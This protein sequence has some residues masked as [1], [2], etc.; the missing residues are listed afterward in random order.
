MDFKYPYQILV[1]KKSQN[2]QIVLVLFHFKAVILYCQ[3][4]QEPSPLLLILDI[5]QQIIQIFFAK[6]FLDFPI[7][8]LKRNKST[9]ETFNEIVTSIAKGRGKWK[10][11]AKKNLEG[12]KKKEGIGEEQ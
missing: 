12:T 5:Y 10:L 4:N 1:T 6:S 2:P 9:N 11:H 3:L 7:L 8:A